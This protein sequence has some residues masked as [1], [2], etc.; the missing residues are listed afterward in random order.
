MTYGLRVWDASANL[1]FDS[2][3]AVG[4]MVA[5]VKTYGPSDTD[6]LTYPTLAGFSV[7]VVPIFALYFGD[8]NVASD[9]TLGYP[10]VIV[11]A[12]G[13]TRQFLVVVW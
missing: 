13:Y 10:R 3:D 1:V 11:S 5:D 6:T 4:G 9:T 8:F 7:M 2:D 12:A